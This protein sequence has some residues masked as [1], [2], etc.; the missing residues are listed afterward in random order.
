MYA[1]IMGLKVV[2]LSKCLKAGGAQAILEAGVD[3]IQLGF[4]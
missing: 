4:G 3:V 2:F 1:L